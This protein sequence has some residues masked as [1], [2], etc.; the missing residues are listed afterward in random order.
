LL[1][2]FAIP[3]V[4]CLAAY[5]Q[6]IRITSGLADHQ[7]IQRAAD[8]LGA[9]RLSGAAPGGA[10][11]VRSVVEIRYVPE[12]GVPSRWTN[13]ALAQNGQWSG[14][15]KG[16]P[17]GGPYTIEVRAGRSTAAINDVYVGD[18]WILAGQSNMEGVGDL[19]DV[20]KPDPMVH[21]FDMFD[22]WDI[23]K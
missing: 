12:G 15:F 2:R 14:G 20:Q 11:E 10:V 6:D 3:L 16:I 13:L 1:T 22:Q 18:L 17:A 23:A 21:A 5:P 4:F 8:G 9:I 7:V 19:V